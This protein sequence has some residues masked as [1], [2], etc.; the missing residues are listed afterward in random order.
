MIY[1][2]GHS[3]RKQNTLVLPRYPPARDLGQAKFPH[4]ILEFTHNLSN[5]S[6]HQNLHKRTHSISEMIFIVEK[7]SKLYMLLG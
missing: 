2:R 5:V 3:N 7:D 1:Q 4:E 6:S